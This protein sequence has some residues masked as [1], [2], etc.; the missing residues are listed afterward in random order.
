MTDALPLPSALTLARYNMAFVATAPLELPRYREPL[1]RGGLGHALKQ[2]ACA[3]PTGSLCTTCAMP[4]LC[5]YAHL[6]ESRPPANAQVLRAAN[7]VPLPYLFTAPAGPRQLPPGTPFS[8]SL[9][10]VGNAIPYLPYLV[11]ALRL[12]GHHGLG[13]KRVRA[14]LATVQWQAP[15]G[16]L[17]PLYS[18]PLNPILRAQPPAP[19]VATWASTSTSTASCSQLTLRFLTP[20]ALKNQGRTLRGA[21]PFVILLRALLRRLS[22][23]A[24]FY[25]PTPWALD[26][27]RWITKAEAIDLSTAKVR[28]Q[29]HRRAS[30]RTQQ[31]WPIGGITGSVTY[32]GDLT[33]FVPLLQ[34]GSLI[35][36][37]NNTVFGNGRYIVQ[38]SPSR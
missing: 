20:L 28:W 30:S 5:A 19:S 29:E 8:F 24:A 13:R 14:T 35:H 4:D 1:L 6:F 32:H 26:Y 15:D 25:G 22:A 12:V 9:T 27:R 38:P 11:A 10:L 37:G 31:Q 16:T 34:L 21:P 36:A 7:A 17:A 33:P 23:L 3:Q 2:G 18:D